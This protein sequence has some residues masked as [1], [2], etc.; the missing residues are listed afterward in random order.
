[1]LKYLMDV[2]SHTPPEILSFQSAVPL[3]RVVPKQTAIKISLSYVNCILLI[4][5]YVVKPSLLKYL[6]DV[7][8]HICS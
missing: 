1:M 8:S 3:E 6:M 2:R 7:R 4:S 5:Y